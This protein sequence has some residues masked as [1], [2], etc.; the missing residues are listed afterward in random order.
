MNSFSLRQK[1]FLRALVPGKLIFEIIF[2][3][4]VLLRLLLRWTAP[5]TQQ[6]LTRT[7]G[8]VAERVKAL[9]FDNPDRMISVRPVS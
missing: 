1:Q 3:F 4:R 8:P 9:N 6:E 2:R 5:V 7:I